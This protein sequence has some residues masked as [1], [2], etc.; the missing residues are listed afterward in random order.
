MKR[1]F[2]LWVLFVLPFLSLFIFSSSSQA[3]TWLVRQDGSGDCTTIQACIDLATAPDTILV[4]P[5]TYSERIRVGQR[6]SGICILSES[7]PSQTTIDGGGYGEVVMFDS[8]GVGTVLRG[9]TVRNGE[10]SMLW[11]TGAG[12]SCSRAS[13]LIEEN[14]IRD[15]RCYYDGSTPGIFSQYG[16]CT[17]RRNLVTGNSHECAW[18]TTGII[19]LFSDAST[20][21]ENTIAYNSITDCAGIPYGGAVYAQNSSA[22][23]AKNIIAFNQCRGVYCWHQPPY[24]T[25]TCNDLW[26]NTPAD[27]Y[28]CDPGSS[29]ISQDPR[30]CAPSAGDFSLNCTSPCLNSPGCGQMGA[31][32]AGCGPT[33]VQESTWGRIKTL[34]R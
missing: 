12:I 17:I 5:G 25:L 1:G 26:A 29:D 33:A 3:R 4:S 14:V 6:G 27:Y 2:L 23:I 21:E 24:P 19:L 28:D 20:V 8:A 18:V 30:F 22:T 34:F 9:F 11:G 32:G 31:F 10:L 7:G 16:T 15:N 13:V